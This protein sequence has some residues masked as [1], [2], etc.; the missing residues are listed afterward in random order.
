MTDQVRRKVL[1]MRLP[2][3]VLLVLVGWLIWLT[4]HRNDNLPT[5]QDQ[6]SEYRYDHMTIDQSQL[7]VRISKITGKTEILFPSG[8]R[9]AP[10]QPDQKE[11]NVPPEAL[12]KIQT[13]FIYF[14][15]SSS[16]GFWD[17][18]EGRGNIKA[19]VQNG[20]NWKLETLT[21]N[22]TT[23]GPTGEVKMKDRQYVLKIKDGTGA[24]TTSSTFSGGSLVLEP[25][26]RWTATLVGA[27]GAK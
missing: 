15:P 1:Q 24:S 21:V 22:V 20:S 5:P 2:L 25:G 7:L 14:D 18:I 9:S 3:L 11:S 8:W 23:I 13:K 12:A 16:E 6:L 19:E 10:D 4:A 26:E 17:S 27:T